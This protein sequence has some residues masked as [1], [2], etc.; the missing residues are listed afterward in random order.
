MAYSI[1]VRVV[2]ERRLATMNWYPPSM[3]QSRASTGYSKWLTAS[4]PHRANPDAA[5]T[6][7]RRFR[8]HSLKAVL[9]RSPSQLPSAIPAMKPGNHDRKPNSSS[10]SRQIWVKPF[11]A[12]QAPG[13][14]PERP[15]PSINKIRTSAAPLQNPPEPRGELR[16][17]PGHVEVIRDVGTECG[18]AFRP[19]PESTA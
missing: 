13:I 17:P 8:D 6:H 9:R 10:I 11:A 18:T 3:P 12:T 16:T 14:E 1:P 2:G 4:S 7:C 15:T 5:A 19:C